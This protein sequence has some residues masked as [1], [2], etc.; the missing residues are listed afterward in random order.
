VKGIIGR[1]APRGGV[2]LAGELDIGGDQ[3]ALD[4]R[5]A[6]HCDP[7]WGRRRPGQSV[8][9]DD[10]REDIVLLHSLFSK[11]DRAA[12]ESPAGIAHDLRQGEIALDRRR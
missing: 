12:I 3:R 10:V 8:V 1:C 11:H 4:F 5:R 2:G 7:Q 9:D 6:A